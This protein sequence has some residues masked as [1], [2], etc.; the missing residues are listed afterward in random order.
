MKQ[1]TFA[2][3]AY[4]RKKKQTRKETCLSAMERC[5]PWQA[6]MAVIAP[7]SSSVGRRGGEPIGLA[8][9][10]RIYLARQWFGLSDPLMEDSLYEKGRNL[11]LKNYPQIWFSISWA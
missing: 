5:M 1:H 6:L 9:M 8:V 3:L 4:A 2:S 11:K 7:R 10:P